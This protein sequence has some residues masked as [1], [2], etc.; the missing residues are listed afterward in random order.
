MSSILRLTLEPLTRSSPIFF[1]QQPF[2]LRQFSSCS[3]KFQEVQAQAEPSQQQP[4]ILST[5]PIPQP[6]KEIPDVNAF[7]SK[8]G[9][10][11]TEHA[12]LF[13]NSWEKLFTIS[14][15]KLRD[16]GVDCQARKYIL[17][18]RDQF[19]K[20]QP[21]KKYHKLVKKNG[22]ERNLRAYSAEKL[23]KDRIALAQL[24]KAYRKTAGQSKHQERL[25]NTLHYKKE[26]GLA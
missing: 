23:I 3:N 10:D 1:T 11:M 17:Y 4:Q 8:I 20:G 13:E 24:Q 22:G 12:D 18:W 7:L 15:K 5:K 2:L 21:L 6:T 14:S 16:S 9:R 25:W 26:N 19:V